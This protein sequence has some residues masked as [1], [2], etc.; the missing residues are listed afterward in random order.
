LFIGVF[1]LVADNVG[2]GS[3]RIV[4]EDQ[5]ALCKEKNPTK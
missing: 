2:D 5:G 1:A 3:F 4:E